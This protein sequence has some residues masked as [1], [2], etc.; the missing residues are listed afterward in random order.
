MADVYIKNGKVYKSGI[1]ELYTA[2]ESD[3][4]KYGTTGSSGTN[5]SSSSS[6]SSSKSGS[7]S[8]PAY[9]NLIEG[10]D[11]PYTPKTKTN[12]NKTWQDLVDMNSESVDIGYGSDYTAKPNTQTID[13]IIK[14]YNLTGPNN[15][16]IE[17]YL[18]SYNMNNPISADNPYSGVIDTYKEQQDYIRKMREEANKSALNTGVERLQSQLADTN[19][20]FDEAG[21]QAYIRAT[22]AE[23]A[24][25]NQLS[26]LGYTGGLSETQLAKLKSNYQNSMADLEKQ[27]L[28]AQQ[29]IYSAIN[30]LRNT[31]D[32]RTAEENIALAEEY[33]KRLL[34]LQ[35]Q[36]EQYDQTRGDKEWADWQAMAQYIPDYTAEI[37]KLQ[38]QK[39]AGSTDSR[40]NDKI[41]YLQY[42]KQEKLNNIDSNG[43]KSTQQ[44]WE[45]NYQQAKLMADMGD[46]SGLKALGYDTTQLEKQWNANLAKTYSSGSSGTKKTSES[47]IN[48]SFAEDY[49][50]IKS[51]SYADAI[52][53]LRN[54]AAAYMAYY[55][56]DG[57]NEL[58]NTA[59]EDAIRDGVVEGR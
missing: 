54:N 18:N 16:P 2:T 36:A 30:E 10:Y 43:A 29:E 33:A 17:D 26:A 25:P 51:L 42:K 22:Q 12:S 58:W 11:V 21:R 20:S 49:K 4:K 35:I 47:D 6:S 27:R 5:T 57:Y 59:L 14:K 1:G 19:K 45:N 48:Q 40:I 44:E 13:D 15:Q 32:Q 39:S 46:F 9:M 55:G 37:Q 38:A 50:A 23:Y 41:A 56:L 52:A 8:Q 28:S 34:E 53:E 31:A 3:Y 7:S 24:L